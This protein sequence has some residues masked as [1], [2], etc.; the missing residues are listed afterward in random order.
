MIKSFLKKQN[1]L[2]WFCI[3]LAILFFSL[4]A[5]YFGAVDNDFWFLKATGDE[6]LSQGT[7][8]DTNPFFVTH[9]MPIVI[10]QWLWCILCSVIAPYGNIGITIIQIIQ[11]VLITWLLL[12]LIKNHT[13]KYSGKEYKLN[14]ASILMLV[15]LSVFM[16]LQY[17]INIRPEAIT[18]ILLLVQ[19]LGTERFISTNHKFWLVLLPLTTLIEINVHASMWFM[20]YCVLIPYFLP[21]I[22]RKKETNIKPFIIPMVLM[23]ISLFINPVGY[24]A[25]WFVFESFTMGTFKTFKPTEMQPF[26]ISPKVHFDVFVILMTCIFVRA[27][28]SHN[29]SSV[30]FYI[31]AGLIL[32]II[33]NLKNAMFMPILTYYFFPKMIISCIPNIKNETVK[34]KLNSIYKPLLS[35]I[36]SLSVI[37]SI[38]LNCFVLN[39]FSL[40]KD[41]YDDN[42]LGSEAYSA[43]PIEKIIYKEKGL[44]AKIMTERGV[45]GYFQSK[46]Y[47]NLYMD[48]RTESYAF[49]NTS[50]LKDT[51]VLGEYAKMSYNFLKSQDNYTMKYLGFGVFKSFADMSDEE[52]DYYVEQA[53]MDKYTYSDSEIDNILRIYDFDYII[54]QKDWRLYRYLDKNENYIEDSETENPYIL[55]KKKG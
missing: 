20:H 31:S 11:L 47:R 50:A 10:Q 18:I 34:E 35:S 17:I 1:L 15:M 33:R 54:V 42:I 28:K 49:P 38:I 24:K 5:N 51:S 30:E 4:F 7:V 53:V 13:Y 29:L 39:E 45:G 22:N 43:K 26:I 40:S 16:S 48:F 36:I 55:F 2:N 23:T 27:L 44:E 25:I 21:F 3:S 37:S 9:D 12:A 52:K 8:P 41:I 32:L 14:S 19:I 6:I 46:G